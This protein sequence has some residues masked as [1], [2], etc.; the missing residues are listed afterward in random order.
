[1]TITASFNVFV[2]MEVK[3]DPEIVENIQEVVKEEPVD[4]EVEVDPE[5]VENIHKVVKEEPVMKVDPE[6]ME[7]D[8]RQMEV[9]ISNVTSTF[10]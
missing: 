3:L 8:L 5:I 10:Q 9:V 4:M 7:K 1:M 6:M 2:K